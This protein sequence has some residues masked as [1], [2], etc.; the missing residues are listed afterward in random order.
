MRKIKFRGKSANNG[1]WI[2]G[3][4]LVNHFEEHTI[5]GKDFGIKVIPETVGQYVG[6]SDKTNKEIYEGDIV[7]FKDITNMNTCNEW[8]AGFGV[9]K[10]GEYDC[11]CD[12]YGDSHYGFYIEGYDEYKRRD[13]GKLDRYDNFKSVLEINHYKVIGNLYENPELIKGGDKK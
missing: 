6:L 1:K 11:N 10:F 2:Y 8:V 3:Y 9:I 12:E 4:F 7:S 13:D 5:W